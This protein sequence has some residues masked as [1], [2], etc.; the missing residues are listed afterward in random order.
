ANRSTLPYGVEMARLRALARI[1]TDHFR[2]PPG[3][4][5]LTVA[6][7]R[8]H[9]G[10]DI[11]LRAIKK[12]GAAAA[13]YRFVIVGDGPAAE[14]FK[15]L[16][17]QLGIADAI[18][19]TGEL[20]LHV[21]CKL[22][23]DCEFFVLPSRVEPFGIVLLEAMV[24]GKAVLATNVGGVK[25]FVHDGDNGVLVEPDNSDALAEQIG[26]LIVDRELRSRIGQN[27]RRLIEEKYDY[28]SVIRKYESLFQSFHGSRQPR[29]SIEEKKSP[30]VPEIGVLALVPDEWDESWQPR[31]HVL[32]RLSRYFHVAWV[33]PAPEWRGMIGSWAKSRRRQTAEI[34]GAPG[35]VVY[36]SRFFPKLYRSKW[37]ANFIYRQRLK[38]ARRLLRLRGCKKIILY[39]WRPEFET[40]IN[41]I[42]FD[43][44][45]YHIDDEYSFSE[46]EV[47]PDPSEMRLIAAVDQV[48][49][50]SRGLLEK[51]GAINPRTI[52]VPNG[53]DYLAY[54]RPAAEPADLAGI[55]HP[56]VGYT[57][58]IKRQLDWP[59]LL[60]VTAQHP[61][62]SFVFVGPVTEDPEVKYAVR[63]LS[64]RSNVH[65]LGY[66]PTLKL[67]AYPQHFDVCVMPYRINDYTKYI[68]P[69]KLHEYLASGR[70]VV[71]STVLSLQEFSH[72][73][74]LVRSP[75]EWSQAI[76]DS[77]APFARSLA[78]VEARQ[79]VARNH[80]WEGL[81]QLI[82]HTICERLG[83]VWLEEIKL[84]APR[85]SPQQDASSIVETVHA[86]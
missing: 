7:L 59:L 86:V 24:F 85:T 54:S 6:K 77:L 1:S 42:P 21:I 16:A 73:V 25:E 33:N 37:L 13:G 34:A 14:A 11:L 81:V 43:E 31:H 50:H 22:Y 51:K 32:T 62:W 12:L 47:P 45:C 36:R 72:V 52:F 82:A 2:L 80:D 38:Q 49:I 75:D 18:V 4:Y 76:Q 28:G 5:I 71:G 83:K 74:S 39:L 68:Y 30:L 8:P 69:L 53:C 84:G 67:A 66:K 78:Q 48:F 46:I 58:R 3:P 23:E 40:A 10:Q 57:G 29:K 64:E 26:R 35:F 63:Q 27:G 19:F 79:S 15:Q 44:S 17:S 41:F 61:E 70:P 56:R 20:Q 9:K 60:Q 65:F 55:P